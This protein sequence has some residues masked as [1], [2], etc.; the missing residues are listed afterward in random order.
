MHTSV[1]GSRL[2]APSAK[3]RVCSTTRER[4]IDSRALLLSIARR[5]AVTTSHE[6]ASFHW[7]DP[8]LLDAR[9]SVAEHCFHEARQDSAA[10]ELTSIMKP[11]SC[12][13]SLNIARTARDMLGGSGIS[14]G[15]GTARHLVNL[16][17]V[18]SHDGPHDVHALI[19]GRA[20]TGVA[21]FTN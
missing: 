10:V 15:F 12:G 11:N 2:R 17:V 20:A 4:L 19:L 1:L 9:V 5:L 3:P 14:D 7:N 16:G 13:K 6:H 21:A 18:N 8:L